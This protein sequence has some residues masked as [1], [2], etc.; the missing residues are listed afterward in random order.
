MNTFGSWAKKY[1]E[2]GYSPIPI[3]PGSKRPGC[4]I[5]G[6]ADKTLGRWQ[7]LCDNPGSP[8][9]IDRWSGDRAQAGIGIALGYN[10]VVAIDIDI[11]P[12][13]IFNTLVDILPDSE[14]VKKGKKGFTAFFR[15]AERLDA[16]KF[17]LRLDEHGNVVSKDTGIRPSAVLEILS[18]GNQT[19]IPPTIHPETGAAYK[20]ENDPLSMCPALDLPELDA[21]FPD[22]VKEALAPWGYEPRSAEHKPGVYGEAESASMYSDLNR[23]ALADLESWIHALDR[24]EFDDDHKG[25]DYRMRAVWRG[26]N[27]SSSVRIDSE[28]I[29]D[30]GTDEVISPIDLVIYANDL[31]PAEAYCWLFEKV[32]GW[33]YKIVDEMVEDGVR[34]RV[35]AEAQE[36]LQYSQRMQQLAQVQAAAEAQAAANIAQ[37]AEE[38]D[39]DFLS[40]EARGLINSWQVG[41]KSEPLDDIINSS[42]GLLRELT[43]ICYSASEKDIR[44]TGFAAAI[45]IMSALFG[46]RWASARTGGAGF[47]H[48]NTLS[49][50]SVD[51]GAGKTS[52]TN[53]VKRMHDEALAEALGMGGEVAIRNQIPVAED[54]EDGSQVERAVQTILARLRAVGDSPQTF[55]ASGMINV[56][57]EVPNSWTVIDECGPKL[58]DMLGGKV[59]GNGE[60]E[61]RAIKELVS[62]ADGRYSKPVYAAIKDLPPPLMKPSFS[63]TMMGTP[64]QIWPNIPPSAYEDG[65]MGRVLFIADEKFCF[66]KKPDVNQ[67][68]RQ[69]IIHKMRDI[70]HSRLTAQNELNSGGY[71]LAEFE[72]TIKP[73]YRT[74]AAEKLMQES[75]D[76]IEAEALRAYNAKRPDRH[77]WGRV[78]EIAQRMALLHALG[79][80]WETPAITEEDMRWGLRI[81]MYSIRLIAIK[82]TELSG[83]NV[84]AIE[85]NNE[86]MQR[87]KS[88]LIKVGGVC[89]M[90]DLNRAVGVKKRE[91]EEVIDTMADA[92][93]VTKVP[94][95]TRAGSWT[96][97]L[98][99]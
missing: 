30:Y 18:Y 54:D 27:S 88:H 14:W 94:S 34:K 85:I 1:I 40:P 25:D 53:Y 22:Q 37:A 75:A 15:T 5:N 59:G 70:I 89:S 44:A 49:I 66:R 7:R 83:T 71:M 99:R 31:S 43:D 23:E 39:T 72:P 58:R 96:I 56:I 57:T 38:S 64:E 10:N 52:A 73:V 21:D 6:E 79:N 26:G 92:G 63:V 80:N 65:F 90:G 20:W 24:V 13:E 51:S 93:E 98:V 35:D 28:C 74:D 82:S 91:G 17:K 78:L 2:A 19:V 95:I 62:A 46:R 29:F 77:L 48:P 69:A 86:V 9:E 16:Q 42:S 3:M 84:A 50:I 61:G 11:G 55:S 60:T 47:T 41:G 97:T 87:M 81:A 36:Q 8:L 67:G 76:W 4:L 68:K 45:G 33:M 32:N 12:G